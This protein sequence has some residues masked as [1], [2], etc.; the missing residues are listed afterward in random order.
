MNRTF[1]LYVKN[2][3]PYCHMASSLIA[4]KGMTYESHAL[5]NQ[6][7]LLQEVQA[8]HSWKTVPMVFETTNGQE[9]FIGGY[10]DLREY[11]DSGKQVLRG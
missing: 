10:D 3:C 11:L 9:K 7:E 1:K 2:S 4:E 8:K 5:D 6:R